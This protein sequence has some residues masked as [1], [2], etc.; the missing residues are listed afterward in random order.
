M[1]CGAMP[2]R[3]E[4]KRFLG[5]FFVRNFL[6]EVSDTFKNFKKREFI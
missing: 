6:E 5:D 1:E 4:L 3:W 2:H